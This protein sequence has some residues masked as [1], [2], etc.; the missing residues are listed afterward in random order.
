MGRHTGGLAGA[1]LD[2]PQEAL[3]SSGPGLGTRPK[4]TRNQPPCQLTIL[5]GGK[6]AGPTQNKGPLAPLT[7][8][9][10][11][12]LGERGPETGSRT[13]H[14]TSS[15]LLPWPPQTPTTQV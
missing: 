14:W 15:S 12:F 2:T 5:G 10:H 3:L 13:A 8:I 1:S 7:P 6:D 4:T 9:C 11:S